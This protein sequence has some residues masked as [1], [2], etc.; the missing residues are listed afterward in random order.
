METTE[1]LKT[2][3][4]LIVE[5]NPGDLRIIKEYFKEL[6]KDKY[7]IM[8]SPTLAGGIDLI[9]QYKFDA[10]FLDLGLPDS[11]GL[12]AL[13]AI[14]QVCNNLPVIVLT[15][16]KN[17]EIGLESIKHGAQDFIIKD[18]LSAV[19]LEKSLKYS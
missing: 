5:D 19:S 9:N 10:V 3:L 16:N 17:D 11:S 18:Q 13:N 4:I 2:Y 15:I 14:R 6:S 8:D 1:A 12:Q 7:E